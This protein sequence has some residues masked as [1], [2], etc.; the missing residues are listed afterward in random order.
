MKKSLPLFLI[1]LL[2]GL[3]LLCGF[4]DIVLET[5]P[6][7]DP[8]L[9]GS[10]YAEPV[11]DADPAPDEE[12]GAEMV[13]IPAG[14]FLMGSDSDSALPD[15]RPV[16]E[17]TLNAYWID[18]YEVT[19]G[20]FSECVAAGFCYE[21]REQ[22][23]ALRPDYYKNEAFADYPVIHVDWNQAK[24][25]CSWAGKRLPTE[26][27]WEKAARGEDGLLY[28]WG[29]ELPD[30][31]PAQIGQFGSG[32]TVP[33]DAF[34]EGCSPYGV[35]GM[36]GNVWEWTSDQYDPD[37]YEKSPAF[38]PLAVTGGNIYVIRG[39][40]WAYPFSLMDITLRNSAYV[41]THTWDLG[42]RCAADAE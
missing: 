24:A 6:T 39:Y 2:M 1:L 16:H 21:P 33:A 27:E 10:F 28:P 42:F 15:A 26:A 40:S 3:P 36:A 4:D 38:D 30:V 14:P 23:S 34:P 13:L 32:D 22:G 8:F 5:V 19:N 41:L 7:F 37:F 20:Q 17:V 12:T 29:N 25:Y 31:V 11:S 18:R 35:C 9:S